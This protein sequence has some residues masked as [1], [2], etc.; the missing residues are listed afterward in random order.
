ME[1]GSL[2]AAMAAAFIFARM[3]A[4]FSAMDIMAFPFSVSKTK[5]RHKKT[6][7]SSYTT[8]NTVDVTQSAMNGSANFTVVNSSDSFYQQEV[9]VIYD[10]DK[11]DLD[12]LVTED[13]TGYNH[14]DETGNSGVKLKYARYKIENSYA[15]QGVEGKTELTTGKQNY[16]LYQTNP[17]TPI[18]TDNQIK[19]LVTITVWIDTSLDT[20][21]MYYLESYSGVAASEITQEVKS[22]GSNTYSRLLGMTVSFYI[23][24]DRTAA[25][26]G[27]LQFN[28]K[29]YM[30]YTDV[31][32]TAFAGG[33][34]TEASPY[35]ISNAAQ[36][37][38][39]FNLTRTNTGYL[40][41]HYKLTADIN[42]VSTGK[43]VSSTTY[44]HGFT[45]VGNT[46]NMFTGVFDGGGHKKAA[47]CTLHAADMEE[48]MNKIVSAM[49]FSD[50]K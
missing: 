11:F 39:F 17:S 7:D 46:T 26:V 25:G 5:Q 18:N 34:G 37:A 50:L 20:R 32:A 19:G 22:D 10:Y 8:A 16:P 15:L 43:T 36:L 30:D 28:F 3:A 45:P 1:L 27:K 47:G 14:Q 33:S 23:L 13:N 44:G 21:R 4:I 41:K 35:T 38:R 42:Y 40:S 49:D 12:V 2:P 9:A 24:S 29:Q 6:S 48:A 31:A